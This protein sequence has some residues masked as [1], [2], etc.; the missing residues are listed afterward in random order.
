[1]ISSFLIELKDS[2]T[3]HMAALAAISYPAC[4]PTHLA[5]TRLV[6]KEVGHKA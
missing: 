4:W 5:M 1:M 3:E 6:S 2:I